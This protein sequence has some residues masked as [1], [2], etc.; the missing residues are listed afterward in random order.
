VLVC[1]LV[2]VCVFVCARVH[3]CVYVCL[4]VYVCVRV[5]AGAGRRTGHHAAGSRRWRARQSTS[6]SA[7]LEA[8]QHHPRLR[9][10]K[11][12][13]QRQQQ[14][15]KGLEWLHRCAPRHKQPSV[16][17]LIT[18]AAGPWQYQCCT[19]RS[20]HNSAHLM[21]TI[22]AASAS[23]ADARQRAGPRRV[24]RRDRCMRPPLHA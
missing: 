1:A 23:T 13:L 4:C 10:R 21:L 20:W 16:E 22:A 2:H 19:A 12:Q 17:F 24:R 18:S 11:R 15:Q 14:R 3:V 8:Q 7:W 9:Q 5:S 6:H